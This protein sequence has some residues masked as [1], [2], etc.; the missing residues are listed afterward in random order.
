ME[1][2]ISQPTK[3]NVTTLK[4]HCKVSDNFTCSLLSATGTELA[5]QEQDYVPAFMPGTHY[6][7]YIILDIDIDTGAITNWRPPTVEQLEAFIEKF[8]PNS[9]ES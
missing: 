9:E 6:G 2:N 1:L 8:G 3:V 7:D 5:T 4:V